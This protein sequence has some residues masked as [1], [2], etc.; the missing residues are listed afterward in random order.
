MKII[1]RGYLILKVKAP[2]IQWANKFD[3]EFQFDDL[4]D[5]EPS[6]YLIEEDF[7]DNE[8]IIKQNFKKIFLNEL[9]AVS[10]DEATYPEIREEDFYNW[11]MVTVGTTVFDA[12]KSDLNRY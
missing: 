2:F 4:D 7:F 12:E 5:L 11:F 10:D 8:Q 6:I 3:D 1:N 9:M